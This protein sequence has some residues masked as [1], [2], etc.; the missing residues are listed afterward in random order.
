M[1]AMKRLA[2]LVWYILLIALAT[3]GVWVNVF[4][5]IHRDVF[6]KA[7]GRLTPSLIVVYL[8][9][10]VFG[11]IRLGKLLRSRRVDPD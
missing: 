11:T 5:Y 10:L 2:W 3:F 6:R 7:N 8:L 9:L 4:I 1:V